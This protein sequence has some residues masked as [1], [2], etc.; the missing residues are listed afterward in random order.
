MQFVSWLSGHSDDAWL[1]RMSVLSM[2]SSST[3]VNPTVALDELQ[4]RCNF[5]QRRMLMPGGR[6]IR[7]FLKDRVARV[8]AHPSCCPARA[9]GEAA[10]CIAVREDPPAAPDVPV[11]GMGAGRPSGCSSAAAVAH[12]CEVPASGDM[13]HAQISKRRDVPSLA[14]AA[15]NSLD[16]AGAVRREC[17]TREQLPGDHRVT[18]LWL[19]PIERDSPRRT[20][21]VPSF[22]VCL[23]GWAGT[24]H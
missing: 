15:L 6:S 3:G 18:I 23:P 12:E 9:A 10:N 17:A 4:D 16:F 20:L 22:P 2:R 19:L 21:N 1:R 8:S 5:H 24:N 7:T 13:A 11:R 14:L